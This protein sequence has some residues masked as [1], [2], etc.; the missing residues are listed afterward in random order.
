[1]NEGILSNQILC[2]MHNDVAFGFLISNA[3]TDILCQHEE[4]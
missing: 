4:Q 2:K 3:E 1:M